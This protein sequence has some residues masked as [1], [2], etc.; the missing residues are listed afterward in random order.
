MPLDEALEGSEKIENRELKTEFK[1]NVQTIKD[2]LF[3]AKESLKS[4]NLII[5][6]VRKIGRNINNDIKRY[7]NITPEILKSF[8]K[9]V[10]G[11][12][13]LSYDFSKNNKLFDFIMTAERINID[14]E[15]KMTR[16][17]TVDS[18]TNIINKI[19]EYTNAAETKMNTIS[20][21]IDRISGEI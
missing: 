16:E 21:E 17:F 4:A 14:Y 7:K 10:T 18:V 5:E 13:A 19:T 20:A 15:M 3:K 1:Y 12:T 6:E 2:N 11:Y 8:K 9:L